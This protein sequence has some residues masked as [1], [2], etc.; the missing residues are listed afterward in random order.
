MKKYRITEVSEITITKVISAR[1]KDQALK[2][3]DNK[4]NKDWAVI[5]KVAEWRTSEIIDIKGVE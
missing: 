2:K 4:V 1:N 5:N 3:F